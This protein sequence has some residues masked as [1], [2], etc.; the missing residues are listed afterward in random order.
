MT[1]EQQQSFEE[2]SSGADHRHGPFDTTPDALRVHREV[3]HKLGPNR[4]L[5][6]AMQM[7]NMVRSFVEAGVRHRHPNYD[8]AK[9]RMAVLLILQGREVFQ[10]CF[11]GCDVQP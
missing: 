1:R 7:S 8:D 11:P 2:S 6:M 4:R 10:K 5:E 9:V 3:L